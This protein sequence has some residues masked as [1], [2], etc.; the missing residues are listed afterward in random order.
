MTISQVLVD[1][2]QHCECGL[3]GPLGAD[4]R[5]VDV[6]ATSAEVTERDRSMEMKALDQTWSGTIDEAQICL[7]DL[8][9][10]GWN[11]HAGGVYP[12]STTRAVVAT[13][14]S[15]TAARFD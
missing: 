6:A 5:E 9:H 4:G 8:V 11:R 14:R 13:V 12:R 1:S 7:C 10:L 3:P 15:R 2:G